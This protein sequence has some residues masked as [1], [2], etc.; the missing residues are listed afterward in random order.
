MNNI[1]IKNNDFMKNLNQT[2]TMAFLRLHEYLDKQ[3]ELM[4][5]I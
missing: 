5:P 4:E 2:I 3:N 1:H